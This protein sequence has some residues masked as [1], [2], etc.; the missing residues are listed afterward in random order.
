MLKYKPVR[1]LYP[2]KETEQ[3]NLFK[4]FFPYVEPPRIYF[5]G[6]YIPIQPAKEFVITDTTFRDGQQARVPY[7]AEQIETIYKFLHKLSGPKGIIRQTEFF[8]YTKKDRE[9]LERCLALGY[10]YPEITGWIRA[11]KEDLK[12]VK[13]AGLK[14][15]GML[16]SASDYHIFLKLKKTRKQ[17]MED[18][19]AVVKEAL[20]Y[21]IKPRCH[22]EDVTRADIYGFVIPFAIELMK[23]R[24]ESG[25]DIKIRL[26]D[27]LGVG[28]PWAEAALPI[29]VPKLIRALIE[30]AGVPGELL[31]WHGHNDFYKAVIN[32]TTAWLY[33]CSAVNTSLL[34]IGERTGNTPLEAMVFEYIALKG[35]ADGM[36]TTIITEIVNYYKNVLHERIPERQPFVGEEFNSTKAGIHI[37]GIIKNEEIYNPFDSK[38][39]LNRPIQIIITDKSGTAGIAYWIN[40]H[41]G[42]E[43]ENRI[44]KKHPGVAKIYKKILEEY[45]KG[46]ITPISNEEML[47]L[48][49]KYLPELFVSELDHL[50]EFVTKLMIS[51]IEELISHPDIKTLK[52]R[53]IRP[54]F[55]KFLED[56]PYVQFIYLINTEGKPVCGLTNDIE[57]RK[58]F[59]KLL[60]NHTF[61]NRDWFLVPLRKGKIFTSGFYTSRITSELCLTISA[62]V[63]NEY[64]EVI[65]VLGTDIRFEDIVKMENGSYEAR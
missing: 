8:L 41:F 28:V 46:R 60:R 44:D 1:G 58:K 45:E 14:E 26:C 31:E 59:E 23:L 2:L 18:Y 27:T 52:P 29:S 50:R 6:K 25:I 38:R 34:G 57:Y 36:D 33:G 30:D 7:T 24:E 54:L 21:G 3:P 9:A 19:L 35:T 42:L 51:Y 11:K 20:S 62:P 5:D 40:T 49:R 37:D 55:K 39:V 32:A 13:E 48:T 61:E 12:L 63:R 16:T 22:F 56:H 53:K 43:G 64:E 10:K 4:E 17:A 15:T 65:G 47:A